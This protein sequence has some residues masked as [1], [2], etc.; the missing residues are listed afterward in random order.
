ML[1]DQIKHISFSLSVIRRI[2]L[3]PLRLPQQLNCGLENSYVN[4]RGLSTIPLN[5][6]YGEPIKVLLNHEELARAIPDVNQVCPVFLTPECPDSL[7]SS[8][9]KQPQRLL[10]SIRT[11]TPDVCFIL[12]PNI[13]T[14]V[15]IETRGTCSLH[16]LHLGEHE[17]VFV[18]VRNNKSAVLA[19]F[20]Q[21]A[22][23]LCLLLIVDHIG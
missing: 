10:L 2:P 13:K 23:N 14:K 22:A 20:E 21:I 12:T 17:L 18:I 4:L 6:F 7:T 3:Q 15:K 11:L 8:I 19:M 16:S 9:P 1:V 5:P